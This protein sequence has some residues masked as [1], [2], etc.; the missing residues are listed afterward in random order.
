MN[1]A[2]EHAL[3]TQLR[4][5]RLEEENEEQKEEL[6]EEE[7]GNNDDVE[8]GLPTKRDLLDAGVN[9]EEL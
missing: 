6:K 2:G 1:E 3:E 5:K 4:Q 8:Q 7:K 9:A